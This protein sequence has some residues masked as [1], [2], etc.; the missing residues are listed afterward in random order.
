M[1][2]KLKN[3]IWD[4]ED[5][6]YGD[7]QNIIDESEGDLNEN[8]I[9]QFIQEIIDEQPNEHEFEVEKSRLSSLGILDEWDWLSEHYSPYGGFTPVIESTI[10]I[11][12][13]EVSYDD[14]P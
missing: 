2:V 5:L 3:I 8:N 6:I 10:E 1:K 11:D 14:L 9:E 13:K 4:N 7:K 12:G